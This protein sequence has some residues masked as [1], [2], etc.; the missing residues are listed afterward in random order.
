MLQALAP[1]IERI[2]DELLE[3]LCGM[4]RVDFVES[5]CLPLPRS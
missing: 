1:R 4:E 2:V 3:G 5:F